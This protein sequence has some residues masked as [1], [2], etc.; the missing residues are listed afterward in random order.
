MADQGVYD[1]LIEMVPPEARGKLEPA[2][3][4]HEILVHRWY[5][6]ERAG[7]EVDI[8]ET[9]RDYI[10]QRAGR[11]A[12]RGDDAAD[13]GDVRPGRV[14]EEDEDDEDDA[15]RVRRCRFPASPRGW[16]A[17]RGGQASR[18]RPIT[19]RWIWLVPSKIWVTLASRK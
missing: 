10:E 12:R 7:H 19:I 5:L 2:E 11:Q 9:A 13:P 18:L 16:K 3:I 15:D 1:P 4:F 17:T 6:S 8:F 14:P